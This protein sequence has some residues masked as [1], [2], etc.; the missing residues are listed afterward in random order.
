MNLSYNLEPLNSIYRAKAHLICRLYA[1]KLRLCA[2]RALGSRYALP[3]VE[4]AWPMIGESVAEHA[5]VISQIIGAIYLEFLDFFKDKNIPIE[6]LESE[7]LHHDD[8]EALTGDAATDVDGVTRAMKDAAE[9]HSI[10]RQYDGMVC[11]SYMKTR[12][13]AYE[14][15]VSYC[16]KIVKMC[17]AIEL[18]FFAQ[19]CVRNG[20]GKI[21]RNGNSEGFVLLAFG[22]QRLIDKR[23][24][25]EIAPYFADNECQ[26]VSIAEIMY[27]HSLPRLEKLGQPELVEL[28]KLLCAEA[29]EFPFEKYNLQQLPMDFA[30][31]A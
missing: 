4:E 22:E 7:A 29:F 10:D 31:L 13:S 9:T 28:F 15:K 25:G 14:T 30:N 23:A 3:F 2:P 16:S 27:D 1:I 11:H 26:N 5:F 12:Y 8:A 24:Y 20:I 6:I 18:I 19:Y 21:Q 17:D